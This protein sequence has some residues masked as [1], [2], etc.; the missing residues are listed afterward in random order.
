[1]ILDGDILNYF[2]E[3]HI[4]VDVSEYENTTTFIFDIDYLSFSKNASISINHEINLLSFQ[5]VFEKPKVLDNIPDSLNMINQNS[6]MLKAYYDKLDDAIFIKANHFVNEENVIS[7]IAFIISSAKDIDS[8]Y[9]EDLYEMIYD[10]D[11]FD[12]EFDKAHENTSIEDDMAELMSL[13]K[14]R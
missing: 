7:T 8:E 2:R 14:K 4:E 6:T 3:S 9:I 13:L 5:I 12:D 10:E 11:S 1:M